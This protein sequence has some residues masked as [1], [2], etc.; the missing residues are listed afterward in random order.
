[1]GATYHKCLS[2]WQLRTKTTYLCKN[3]LDLSKLHDQCMS[4]L[5]VCLRLA[6]SACVLDAV[7]SLNRILSIPNSSGQP[8]HGFHAG[9]SPLMVAHE[10]ILFWSFLDNWNYKPL[11]KSRAFVFH[12]PC[13]SLHYFGL[14]LK[15][16]VKH[17]AGWLA[18]IRGGP[19]MATVEGLSLNEASWQFN[20]NPPIVVRTTLAPLRKSFAYFCTKK[21]WHWGLFTDLASR[22]C[23]YRLHSASWRSGSCLHLGKQELTPF[24]SETI[25][26][27]PRSSIMQK[28]HQTKCIMM[29]AICCV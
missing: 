14:I 15:S 25:C 6:T 21:E 24:S 12:W 17:F 28:R 3:K 20:I 10:S 2:V 29:K 7:S 19:A 22:R 11:C 23:C 18:M 27:G 26:H 16:M 4:V 13:R 8:R 1:M 5:D 9:V